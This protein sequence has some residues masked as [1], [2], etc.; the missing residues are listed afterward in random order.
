VTTFIGG[1]VVAFAKGWKLT[2][3]ILSVSPLL[4]VTSV[5]FAQLA[6]AL[7]TNELKSYAR[8]GAVAEE[9]FSSIR[10][11]F[12]FNGVKKDHKRYEDKLDEAKKFGIKKSI[13]NGALMGM[14]WLVIN[15]SYALG[16]KLK[17]H[18]FHCTIR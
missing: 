2:L 11:V 15:G 14:L 18:T 1:V 17:L 13:V 12:A 16:I 10:T 8:A 3:V 6:E 9:V 7:S 5:M 4:F